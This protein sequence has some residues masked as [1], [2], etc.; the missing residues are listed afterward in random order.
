MLGHT[1][2]DQAETVLLGLARGSGARSL[3]GMAASARPLPAAAACACAGPRPGR[4]ARR[5]AWSPGTTRTTP[6]RR[7]PGSGCA[8]SCIPAL[9]KRARPGRA[10]RR[11]PGPRACCGPTLTCWTRS[12]RPRRPLGRL[13]RRP[14]RR[15]AGR[16]PG[17]AACGDQAAACCAPA[18]LAAGCPAGALVRSATSP[19][20]DE[21]VTGWHGQRWDRPAGRRPV[22]A[23]VWQAAL[24]Q[25][26]RS[27]GRS[28][29]GS[30]GGI[31][32][33]GW[34]RMTW[35]PTSRRS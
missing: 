32:G 20:L 27:G 29:A 16:G 13:E 31:G 10:P 9:T 33:P 18:A 24:H 15:L 17:R 4:P 7:S 1:L 14:G 8:A 11:W 34:T 26:R 21:L 6:T 23:P 3:A 30:R 25:S 28:P 2:D 22:P 19:S 35:V 12:R 5:W